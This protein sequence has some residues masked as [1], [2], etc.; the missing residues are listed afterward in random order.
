MN[1]K[2][3][4]AILESNPW[5]ENKTVKIDIIEREI[6]KD[7]ENYIGKKQ[8]IAIS[9]LRRV[10][11]TTL[12][13]WIIGNLLK[14]INPKDILYF[15]FDDFKEIE[16]N[17][18]LE[19]SLELTGKTP[20][21]IFFDE[22]QKV[23]NWSEKIK[24]IYDN[25]KVKI[26]L[27]GSESLFIKK[28]TKETLAGR[29]FE[30]KLKP[31]SFKEYL[32]FKG[33]KKDYNIHQKKIILMLNHYLLIGGF[34]ELVEEKDTKIVRKY[35]RESI[36]DKIIF[37]DIPDLFDLEDPSLLNTLLEIIIDNPGMI[38]E[39]NEVSKELG[40]SRQTLSKY[41][42]YLEVSQLIKKIYNYSKNRSTSEKKLKKYYLG[43]HCSAIAYKNDELYIS[44]VVENLCVLHTDAEFFWRT[45]QKDEVDIVLE[46]R[47]IQIPIEIKYGNK[48]N[49]KSVLKL[50]KKYNL[51]K[52]YIVTKEI[53]N[54]G[55][56]EFIPLWK[57]LLR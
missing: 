40:I 19:T 14:T 44:K 8:I 25:K 15:S 11:K 48:P 41:L 46:E 1:Q 39:L 12:L 22:I 10:G 30:F 5:W 45:P 37:K 56:V 50:M 18:I 24:R 49:K 3:K 9:G 28:Y 52:G 26:F 36:I 32:S 33:I 55:E 47:K 6:L 7:I 23:E 51:K 38:L 43:F 20:K 54:K 2:L 17:N 42:F 4:N 34:P 27:S 29:I 21:Y 53:E 57:W 31:L 13:H 35:I 16:L